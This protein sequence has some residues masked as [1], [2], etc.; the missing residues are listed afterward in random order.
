MGTLDDRKRQRVYDRVAESKR[1]YHSD[2]SDEDSA[3]PLDAPDSE[4]EAGPSEPLPKSTKT[5][6]AISEAKP[7]QPRTAASATIQSV[8]AVT[9]VGSGLKRGEDG[10]VIA[11]TIVKRKRKPI[12]RVRTG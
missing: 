10:Q 3:E 12:Q 6:S 8:P 2:G 9:E 11:P 4:I 1:G 7:S 5:A